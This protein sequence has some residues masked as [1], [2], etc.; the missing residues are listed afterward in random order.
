MSRPKIGIVFLRLT[1]GGG[2]EAAA[3]WTTEALKKDYDVSLI[4]IGRILLPELNACYGTDM[5]PGEIR[6]IEVPV[7]K[8]INQYFDVLRG[9]WFSRLWR[10]LSSQ[11]DLMISAYN[12][13][14]FE[15]KGIQ[16]I[17]DFSFDESLRRAFLELPFGIEQIFYL[18]GPHR[19]L[20][21]TVGR[22]ISG[23]GR[24]DWK[25]NMT[26]SNSEWT[27][28]VMK[29]TY[30]L[31]SKVIYPPVIMDDAFLPWDQKETG[32]VFLGRLAPEKHVE[33]IIKILK[34]ARLSVPDLH[35]HIV[36]GM[37]HDFYSRKI[38]R[39]CR[40]NKD[41][42]FYEGVRFQDE[43]RKI[44][45]HHKFGISAR[46]NEPFGIAVAEMT[47]AGNLVFVP[48]GG[49]QVE[50]VDHPALIYEDAAD[51][52]EKIVRVLRDPFLQ[53]SLREHL[54][55]RGERFSPKKFREEIRA[56]VR[57]F[58]ANQTV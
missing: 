35:L 55:G 39:L 40:Q 41:W 42:I 50:I 49:G 54:R 6:T 32:F 30:G 58:F 25:R 11:F 57:E 4:S 24:C 8:C 14:N 9:A 5:K 10:Q 26:V 38:M 52:A 16:F 48:K 34:E 43:K 37:R 23:T 21:R 56:T 7:P 44:I 15:K 2:G 20:Y 47:L 22:M 46:A 18:P 28:R 1:P 12:V 29:R 3:L 45:A 51:A 33:R 13:V 36:G 53:N 17:A 19:W 27:R 31:E